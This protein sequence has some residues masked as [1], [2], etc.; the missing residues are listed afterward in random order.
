MLKTI[1]TIQLEVMA[2]KADQFPAVVLP[3]FAFAGRSNVGKSSLINMLAGRRDV[4]KT[5]SLPGK[6]RTINFYCVDNMWRLVDLPGYGYARTSKQ[7][8]M[9]FSRLIRDYVFQRESLY[10]VFVLID[11]RIEPQPSDLEFI[12]TLGEHQVPLAIVF[13][14]TDKLSTSE[15]NKIN[16]CYRELLLKEWEQLPEF[17]FTSATKKKGR[18]E[19]L[20]FIFRYLP[21]ASRRD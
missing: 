1:H 20:S 13:T 5:S 11:S 15:I 16:A 14:K 10:C 18:E 2:G 7:Q 17:F 21:A 4:A 12:H 9:L 19:L 6:T 8:R 3:E